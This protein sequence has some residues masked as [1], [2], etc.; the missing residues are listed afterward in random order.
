MQEKSRLSPEK[1]ILS[2]NPESNRKEVQSEGPKHKRILSA[3]N[4]NS[5]DSNRKNKK[6]EDQRYLVKK[7]LIAFR[8]Q[9]KNLSLSK[10]PIQPGSHFSKRFFKA[11]IAVEEYVRRPKS[12]IET[13]KR[14]VTPLQLR[15]SSK[16]KLPPKDPQSD[17]W[18]KFLNI[19]PF[20]SS[21]INGS[22]LPMTSSLVLI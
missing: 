13:K 6:L 8:N 17:Y 9:K 16:Q 3:P 19:K 5:K 21:D 10:E 14:E 15:P 12:V 2:S 1:E 11:Q 18:K 22:D 7:R 4:S 20:G